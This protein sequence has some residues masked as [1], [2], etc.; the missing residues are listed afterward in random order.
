MDENSGQII[1]I[2]ERLIQK[3]VESIRPPEDIRDRLDIGYTFTD[4]VLIIFEIRPNWRDEND[5][6]QSPVAKSRFVK[7]K[8][9]WKIYWR[10]ASGKWELYDPHPEEKDLTQVLNII[11]EDTFHCFWG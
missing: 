5:S 2:H 11:K 10:R 8:G 6:I 9:I 1:S 7:S 3:F 4:Q